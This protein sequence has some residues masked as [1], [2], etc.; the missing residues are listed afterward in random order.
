MDIFNNWRFN[1]FTGVMH[2]ASIV[3]EIHIIEYHPEWNAYGIQLKEAPLLENPSSVIIQENIVGG[4]TFTEIPKTQPPD[5]GQYRVDYDAPT[6]FGTGRI[7]F[8]AAD[9]GKEI[10]I[11]YKGTGTIVKKR[12]QLDQY[13]VIST[14]LHVEGFI[15]TSDDVKINV[16]T[17]QFIG[18]MLP[19]VGTILAWAGG[20]MT[21]SANG[22]FS[23][24]QA[25]ANNI[26]SI[27]AALPENWRVCD[28]SELIDS[29]SPI[30]N[31]S[32]RHLPNL[33]DERFISG[34][35]SVG[36]SGG[37]NSM[38]H[39]HTIPGHYHTGTTGYV[40]ADHQHWHT[41]RYTVGEQNATDDDQGKAANNAWVDSSRLTGGIT[42]NHVHGFTTDNN[43]SGINGGWD[44]TTSEASLTDNRPRFLGVIYIMRVK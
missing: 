29:E 31:F 36:G 8:N 2:S 44:F 3:D 27:N 11:S 25:G 19:P 5:S 12:Y 21:D 28:G 23:I 34:S 16:G 4:I 32:G 20:F 35:T 33:T 17:Q 1:P 40:S 13:S 14:N 39:T 30:F 41:D 7:E 43:G 26:S 24:T 6:Y 9:D 10:K 18:N 37:D 38:S 22:G 15:E 42:A